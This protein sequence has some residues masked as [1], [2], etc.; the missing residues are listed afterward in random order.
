[1]SRAALR[2]NRCGRVVV[3]D[4]CPDEAKALVRRSLLI[5]SEERREEIGVKAKRHG[6]GGQHP[7]AHRPHRVEIGHHV[8]ADV[9]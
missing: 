3:E 1:M 5:M 6:K 8:G 2:E 7:V 9:G 4:A